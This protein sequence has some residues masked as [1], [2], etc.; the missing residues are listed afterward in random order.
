MDIVITVLLPVVVEV[1]VVGVEAGVL[2]VL[3]LP[4]FGA[5]AVFRDILIRTGRTGAGPVF[6]L[7]LVLFDDDLAIAFGISLTSSP[8]SFVDSSIMLR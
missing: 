4:I 8:Q 3:K 2:L 6:L 5:A 7:G 1:V